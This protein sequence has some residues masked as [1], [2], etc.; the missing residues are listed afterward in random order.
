MKLTV[1]KYVKSIGFGDTNPQ[2]FTCDD[3]K[4]YVVKLIKNPVDIH[5]LSNELIAY[6]LGA[7]FDLPIAKGEII[8]IT[9][10]FIRSNK[11]PEAMNATAGPHFGSLYIKNAEHSTSTNIKRCTNLEIVPR[12]IA[13]DHW[14]QNKDRRSSREN[15]LVVKE[16]NDY[17]LLLIDHADAFTG[18][19]S[20]SPWLSD[21]KPLWGK[22]YHWFSTVL[23]KK[24]AYDE[25]YKL[26]NKIDK[27]KIEETIG[28]IP[29]EWRV[30][31]EQLNYLI[32]H[33]V[34][35]KDKLKQVLEQLNP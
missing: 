25:V 34:N 20:E 4:D 7:L 14:I 2:L 24:G 10:E 21:V 15:L 16:E 23:T 19:Y 5:V 13:F 33:L 6:R 35:R 8:H 3:G 31:K 29:K 28:E 1:T 11:L 9:D 27:T 18:Y 30:S 12:M 17:K 32:T 26:L 22:V